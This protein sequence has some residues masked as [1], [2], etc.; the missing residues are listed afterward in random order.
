MTDYTIRK[1]DDVPDAFGRQYPG[2]MRFLTE[3]LGNQQVAFTH[4]VMPPHTGGQGSS[5]A[6]QFACHPRGAF[7]LERRT[8]RP[9]ALNLLDP[10]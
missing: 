5:A 1:L 8:R 10:P 4:R 7:G 3:S 2:T 9:G 6:R